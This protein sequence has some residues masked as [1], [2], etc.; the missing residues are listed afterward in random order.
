M[1]FPTHSRKVGAILSLLPPTLS[2]PF[3]PQPPRL[4]PASP[5][6]EGEVEEEEV[7]LNPNWVPWHRVVS[8]TGVISPRPNERGMERQKDWLRNEGVEVTD[9]E[10]NG[11]GGKV[12]MATFRWGG[13]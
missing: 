9:S 8:S 4:L 13:P 10:V 11:V 5:P 2:S 1:G 7:P 6:P 12:K 3:H